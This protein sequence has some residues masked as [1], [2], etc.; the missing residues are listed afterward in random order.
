MVVQWLKLGTFTAE[1]MGLI[2]GQGTKSL[3]PR[4]VNNNNKK[5]E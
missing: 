3:K 5:K 2:P 1:G 4:G